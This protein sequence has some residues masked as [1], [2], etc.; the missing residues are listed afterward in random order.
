MPDISLSVDYRQNAMGKGLPTQI[1]RRRLE[2]GSA[3]PSEAIYQHRALWMHCVLGMGSVVSAGERVMIFT[4]L[5]SHAIKVEVARLA[6]IGLSASEIGA[7]V[8]KSRNAIIGLA[9]RN[10]GMITL[11]GAHAGGPRKGQKMPRKKN[12]AQTAGFMPKSSAQPDMKC[13]PLPPEPDVPADCEPITLL[14]LTD[15]TCR[16]PIGSRD[17]V[18][19]GRRASGGPY[20][21]LHSALAYQPRGCR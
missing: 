16:W 21:R 7:Q 19:C 10:P 8:G 12:P 5:T 2:L 6:D 9:H 20:C 11:Q 1:H 13:Q 4:G 3:L 17:Y 15:E 18:F 14:E